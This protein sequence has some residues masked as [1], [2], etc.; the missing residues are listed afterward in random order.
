MTNPHEEK[1]REIAK[2]IAML[3]GDDYPPDGADEIIA[4]AIREA[5]IAAY[6]AGKRDALAETANAK[7]E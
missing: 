6:E 3:C 2:A 7:K 1:A 4:T 5:E